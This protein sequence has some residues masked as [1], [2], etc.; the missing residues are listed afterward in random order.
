MSRVACAWT[1]LVE[2]GDAETWYENT[3]VSTVANKFASVARNC[4]QVED[5]MFKEVPGING[6]YMTLYDLPTDATNINAQILPDPAK[7]PKD[8]KIET[9]VY[10][11]YATWYGQEWSDSKLIPKQAA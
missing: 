7:L 2:D 9:R 5:N 8:T 6:R 10:D 4:E 1:D 11:E 3:H